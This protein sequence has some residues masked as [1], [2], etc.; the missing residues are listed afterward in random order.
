MIQGVVG[1]ALRELYQSAR[2]IC[3]AVMTIRD[4]VTGASPLAMLCI[5]LTNLFLPFLGFAIILLLRARAGTL[6]TF[7]QSGQ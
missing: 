2:F 3:A 7:R 1:A 6:I 5:G 4:A